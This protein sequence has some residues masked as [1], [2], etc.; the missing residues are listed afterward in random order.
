[1]MGQQPRTESL[2]YYFRLQD[3]IPEDHLL[4]LIDRHIDF[5]FVRE[6][7][8]DF[9]SPTGRPSIDPEVLLRL[10]LVGYLYG[11]TSE[12][13]LLEEVRMHLAYRW[14]TRLGFEKEIPDHSTFS[15]NRHGRFRQCGVFRKVF[16]QI[17]RRCL[18]SGLVEGRNLAVDGTL[19]GANASN[20]SRVSR[21]KLVEV[22]QIS[23]TVQE[24][25]TE[26]ERQNP[27]ADLEERPIAQEM[28]SSTDPDAAWAVKSGPAT[29]GYYDNYLIDT[30]SRVILSVDATPARFSQEVLAARRM[31]ER[32]GQ[33]GVRPQNLAADKAYGSGE[34]LAWLL[35][36]G[37]Q[38]HI[39]VM[40]RQHQ[41]RGRFTRDMF[42]YEPQENAYY[43]PEGKPLHYRGQRRSSR[44]DLY[45]STEAQC[46]G[47]PQKKLC[48]RGS[49]RRLFVHWQEPARQAVRALAGT[50]D[51]KRSQRARYKVEA[52]F[53]ELKQQIKLRRVRLRKLWNVAEQFQ[54]AATAQNLKRLVRHLGQTPSLEP[55]TT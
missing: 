48:T 16:E 18:E 8:K 27:L 33:F 5:S 20:Q 45:R 23:R 35:E 30:T 50:P 39:P 4:R 1:M 25:L 14:F 24:Y 11:I 37:I 53:A 41:T 36:R 49:Y 31:I 38:P 22:A 13:R 29:L 17:V 7:L 46:R 19:V 26:L 12:R 2:F 10:L 54:L 42:R 9:Y 47:C 43:C 44:G 52:L 40:D 21:E 32:V 6:Q 3:Q 15:K 51:Y 55:R 28:V 34:F